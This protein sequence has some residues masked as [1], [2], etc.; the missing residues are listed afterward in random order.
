M[1]DEYTSA[2]MVE[3]R[4]TTFASIFGVEYL[5]GA[6]DP[7]EDVEFDNVPCAVCAVNSGAVYM[8]PG[9][10]ACPSGWNTEYTGFLMSELKRIPG[11]SRMSENYRSEFVCVHELGD[12]ILGLSADVTEAQIAHV[13]VDCSETGIL[14]CIPMGMDSA[15][16]EGQLSCVVCSKELEEM[17]PEP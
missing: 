3:R 10:N 17:T 9:T 4:S 15:Y 16:N 14:P 6:F 1:R 13:H 12:V 2:T 7:L 11:S 5:T 8:Q